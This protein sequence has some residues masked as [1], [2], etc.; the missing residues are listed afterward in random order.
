M[1]RDGLTRLMTHSAFLER[2]KDAHERARRRSEVRP[3][4]VMLDLDRFKSV[5]DSFG[6]AIGDRVLVAFASLLRRRLRHSDVLGRYGG[7]EFGVLLEGLTEPDG[8]RLVEQ[9]RSDF[10]ALAHAS[11]DGGRFHVTVSAGIA[12][13]DPGMSFEE[14]KKAA[15]DALYRAKADGRDRVVIAPRAHA[16]GR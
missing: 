13:L 10:G 6:H 5:N 15:D 1:E 9:L 14:W 8:L 7:E 2:A 16:P 12:C 3:A 4:L 11:S